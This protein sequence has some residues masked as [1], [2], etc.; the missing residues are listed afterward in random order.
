M[1]F[2]LLAEDWEGLSRSRID[3]DGILIPPT[4]KMCCFGQTFQE[5]KLS[6]QVP[7]SVDVQKASALTGGREE[8]AWEGAGSGAD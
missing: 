7:N 3:A 5:S 1:M 4:G 6:L 2:A 8:S